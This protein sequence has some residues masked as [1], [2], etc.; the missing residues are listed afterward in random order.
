M[1]STA[2]TSIG[3]NSVASRS[4]SR[5]GRVEILTRVFLLLP[6]VS[7]FSVASRAAWDGSGFAA[8]SE[9]VLSQLYYW[10]VC[11]VFVLPVIWAPAVLIRPASA[12]TTDTLKA[13]NSPFR[14]GWL[15]R[16]FWVSYAG[17]VLTGAVFLGEFFPVAP[18]LAWPVCAGSFRA[19][20]YAVTSGPCSLRI[21][22]MVA[23]ACIG[24]TAVTSYLFA[25]TVDSAPFVW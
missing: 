1:N 5:F 15:D 23:I 10:A 9:T 18:L 19:L 7:T 3:I 12:T 14:A 8:I 17:S 2:E 13:T 4:L 22:V 21:R 25:E 11:S 20:R 6:L 24:L 16:C